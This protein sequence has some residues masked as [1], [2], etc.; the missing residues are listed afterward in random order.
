M[1]AARETREQRERVLQEEAERERREREAYEA[2]RQA[3]KEELKRQYALALREGQR[4]ADLRSPL[5]LQE[6][7]DQEALKEAEEAL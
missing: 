3:I 7:R 5:E 4:L 1:E 6:E 2:R